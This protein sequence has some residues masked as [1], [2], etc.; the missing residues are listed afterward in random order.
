MNIQRCPEYSELDTRKLARPERFELPTF[1]FVGRR[2][3]APK[4][5]IYHSKNTFEVRNIS[6]TYGRVSL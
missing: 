6:D 1:W 2:S 4:S 5:V 3:L